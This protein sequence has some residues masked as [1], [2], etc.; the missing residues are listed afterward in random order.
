MT[1]TIIWKEETKKILLN[2]FQ[3]DT[4]FRIKEIKNLY[5][6][7][8]YDFSAEKFHELCDGIPNTLVLVKNSKGSICGGFTPLAW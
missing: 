3:N 6:A 7:S 2:F 5:R 1:S 4:Y 8:V